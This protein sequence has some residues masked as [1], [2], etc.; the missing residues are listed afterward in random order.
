MNLFEQAAQSL[1]PFIARDKIIENLGLFRS[2]PDEI[3]AIIHAL[4][5][6]PENVETMLRALSDEMQALHYV[7]DGTVSDALHD[8]GERVADCATNLRVA[9]NEDAPVTAEDVAA[10]VRAA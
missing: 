4:A 8:E 5:T 10:I 6:T 9:I 1:P 3:K 2:Q 7:T